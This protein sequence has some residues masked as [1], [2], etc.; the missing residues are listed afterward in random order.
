MESG[1]HNAELGDGHVWYRSRLETAREA[2][3]KKATVVD[4]SEG[5]RVM[6]T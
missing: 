2:I 4:H 5:C 6:G 1:H 3:Y